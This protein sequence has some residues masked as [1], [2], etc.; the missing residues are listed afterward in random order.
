MEKEKIK[1]FWL[2][3]I[4]ALFDDKKFFNEILEILLKIEKKVEFSEKDLEDMNSWTSLLSLFSKSYRDDKVDIRIFFAE[5][6]VSN[7]FIEFLDLC[8][9]VDSLV[10][11][12]LYEFC[13][14]QEKTSLIF[15]LKKLLIFKDLKCDLV[16]FVKS[17]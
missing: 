11:K 17:L 4:D 9:L 7:L 5:N 10:Y 12:L 1:Q 13:T 15:A 2:D 14:E 8:S 3:S 16:F 6:E